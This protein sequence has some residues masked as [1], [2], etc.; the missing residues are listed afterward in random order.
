MN[1]QFFTLRTLDES[2]PC[3]Y[4]VAFDEPSLAHRSP[5][6]PI[7]VPTA[8]EENNAADGRCQFHESRTAR[9]MSK[10]G[11]QTARRKEG[12]RPSSQGETGLA[13][14]PARV[15]VGTSPIVLATPPHPHRLR[16]Q[17]PD[18][19]SSLIRRSKGIFS[20]K[21]RAVGNQSS[22]GGAGLGVSVGI[23]PGKN[24]GVS[25]VA[26]QPAAHPRQRVKF[27]RAPT[28][29]SGR[30]VEKLCQSWLRRGGAP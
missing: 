30:S 4:V 12:G 25:A 14:T 27:P 28:L 23:V 21:N 19:S 5:Q 29:G 22:R 1:E 10:A 24:T 26:G 9:R 6:G 8:R 2:K 3:L 17:S 13:V 18:S 16:C 11:R 7:A 20:G 15:W